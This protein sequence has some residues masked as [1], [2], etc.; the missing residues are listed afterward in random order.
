M[1]QLEKRIW[2]YIHQE[3]I[4]GHKFE[5]VD[6]DFWE[7]FKSEKDCRHSVEDLEMFFETSMKTNLL[8][9]NLESWIILDLYKHLKIP[10]SNIAQPE[11]EQKFN[12][13][14]K[15][16]EER[17]LL[18]YDYIRKSPVNPKHPILSE[19]KAARRSV[20][21]REAFTI[22]DKLRMAHYLYGKMVEAEEK[23]SPDK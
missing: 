18:D 5:K 3:I 7:S 12:I 1:N 17:F 21:R 19:R 14:M 15:L 13:V 2:V 8:K 6:K 11:I 23:A 16:D 4:I 10:I 9:M 22:R 20:E